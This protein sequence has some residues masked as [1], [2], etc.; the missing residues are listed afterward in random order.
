MREDENVRE[1]VR[2]TFGAQFLVPRNSLSGTETLILSRKLV[3][4][5]LFR[6]FFRSF[7]IEKSGWEKFCF[8]FGWV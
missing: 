5:F 4:K 6:I 8:K 1:R 3:P 2:E 7:E